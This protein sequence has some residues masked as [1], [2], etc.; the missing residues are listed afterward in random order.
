[1]E[2]PVRCGNAASQIQR[3]AA[4]RDQLRAVRARREGDAGSPAAAGLAAVLGPHLVGQAAVALYVALRYEPGTAPLRALL[5]ASGVPVLLPWLQS[6]NDLDWV[7]DGS[8]PTDLDEGDRR[9]AMHPP[10]ELLGRS[11][12]T[13]VTTLV[14]PALAVDTAGR[15]LGQGGGSYDRVLARLREHGAP[16]ALIAC[17]FDDEVLDAERESLPDAPHDERIDQVATPTRLIRLRRSSQR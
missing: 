3:K 13:T 11:A 6:D 4:I 8:P 12:I 9:A 2:L 1:M 16:T 5:A 17:V 14:L 10:G 7:R 15:R